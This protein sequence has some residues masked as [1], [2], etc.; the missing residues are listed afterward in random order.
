MDQEMIIIIMS[1][2][3]SPCS[4]R[5]LRIGQT[6]LFYSQ[7]LREPKNRVNF[8]FLVACV[9]STLD[10]NNIMADYQSLD[11]ENEPHCWAL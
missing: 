4:W 5:P 2:W 3:N 6:H 7:E 8:F 11:S 9:K 1:K 10:G